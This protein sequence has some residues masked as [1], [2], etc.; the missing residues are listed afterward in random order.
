MKNKYT[1]EIVIGIFEADNLVGVLDMVK[2]FPVKGELILGLLMF[3]PAMTNRGL[4]GK[5]HKCVIEWATNLHFDKLRIDVAGDNQES[6]DFWK[7]IG[8]PIKST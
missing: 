4:R 5:M 6:Y 7:N 2:D 3:D 8:L 1:T